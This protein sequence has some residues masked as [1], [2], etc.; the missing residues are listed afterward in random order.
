MARHDIYSDLVEQ[1][2]GTFI[3]NVTQAE[4]SF[5]NDF[6]VTQTAKQEL[7]VEPDRKIKK[8]APRM[9][10]ILDQFAQ[11]KSV[12]AA[13]NAAGI[14]PSTLRY[15]RKN[16]AN[17]DQACIDAWELGTGIYEDEIFNRG[18]DG[19]VA[20]VYH[21]GTVVGQRIEHH[22]NLLVRTA[23]RRAPQEWGR[24]SRV[25]LTGK[26]G[27]PLRIATIDLSKAE[28]ELS[29]LGHSFLT[30]EY[31]ALIEGPKK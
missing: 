29:E 22:D 31:R 9:K 26:A 17:F 8:T 3:A 16:D 30:E 12:G 14:K 19:T 2:D 7:Y 23:E 6:S 5:T 27:G 25:E 24:A 21:Q 15:W 11:G 20:D 13:C 1:A 28:E 4:P 10:L 18:K